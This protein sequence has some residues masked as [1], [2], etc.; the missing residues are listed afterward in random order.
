MLMSLSFDCI[1]VKQPFN[2]QSDDAFIKKL[3]TS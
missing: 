1:L 2:D 3:H